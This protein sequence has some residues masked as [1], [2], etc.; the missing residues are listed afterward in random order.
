MVDGSFFNFDQ[1]VLL[2][3][4]LLTVEEEVN[5]NIFGAIISAFP[6]FSVKR[7][8]REQQPASFSQSMTKGKPK[9]SIHLTAVIINISCILN[10]KLTIGSIGYGPAINL[11]K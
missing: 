9:Y 11:E 10:K 8:L 2:I 3:S 7:Q 4:I 5:K 6:I 1:L